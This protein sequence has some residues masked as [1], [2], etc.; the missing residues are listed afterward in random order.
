MTSADV[1]LSIVDNA[2]ATRTKLVPRRRVAGA[3]SKGIGLSPVFAVMC[4]NNDITSSPAVS[5]PVGDMRLLPDLDAGAVLDDELVWAPADQLDQQLEPM[6]F[7]QRSAAGRLAGA[8]AADG[9]HYLMAF[10][11]EFTVF[12]TEGADVR[13]A[14][15]GPG[16]AMTPFLLLEPF[17][18]DLLAGLEAAGIEVEQV[19]P[20]YG[21]GRVEVSMAPAPPVR[22]ADRYV[23]A[24]LI[25]T[26]TALRH[27]LRCRS[28]P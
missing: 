11:L 19:H 6:P 7:C 28:R 20:E 4:I 15:E 8:A 17:L 25:T 22:A 21:D 24:R 26:R 9:W 10:E 13:P 23:L 18:R 2:A 16:Y 27:G 1:L 3:T 12:R 14:H 5:G